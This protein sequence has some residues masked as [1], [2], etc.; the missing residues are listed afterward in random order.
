MELLS[1][2]LKEMAK[3]LLAFISC[4]VG[5]WGYYP[6]LPAYV[7]VCSMEGK[8][9][10]SVVIGA[11]AG[12]LAFMP[13]NSMIR[14]F[15]ILIVIGLAI[16]IFLWINRSCDS[17]STGIIAGIATV[18]MNFA[19]VGMWQENS[20]KLLMGICEGVMVLGLC[21]GIHA[22][23]GLPFRLDYMWQIW[24]KSDNP[25]KRETIR[26]ASTHRMESLAYAV[27]GLSDA[28]FAMSLP[29]KVLTPQRQYGEAEP[30]QVTEF[31]EEICE[32]CNS[33][34]VCW[35]E[36]H[37]QVLKMAWNN[38]L[39]ENRYVIARQLDAMADLMQ[40]WTKVRIS[41]D[42]K[43]GAALAAIIYGAKEKG[44]LVEDLHVYEEKGRLYT[45]G[46]VSAR[47][48]GGISMKHY[49]HVTEKA[50]GRDMRI[51]EEGK[52]ILT[53]DPVFVSLYEETDFYILQGA[54]TEKKSDS[55]E[56]GDYF[57]YFSMD[58]GNYHICLSDGMGSGSRAKEESEMVVELMQKFIEAGF[59]KETAVQLLNSTMV[60]QGEDNSFSTLD[61]AV[62]D[63]Y[64]GELELIKIGGAAT[65]IKHGD[66]VECID[67]G[68]LPAGAD[69]K[70]EVEIIKRKL[71]SGDFLVMV[72]DGM[73]EYLH[74][75]SPKDVMMDMISRAKTE[76]AQGLAEYIMTQVMI[77]TGGFPKDDMTI[78]V[79][80]I[81]EK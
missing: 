1:K 63:T 62:I 53:K 46:Y 27:S 10:I 25:V 7:A 16:R 75:R 77:L 81:W 47:L 48:N 13:F 4:L 34:E 20:A 71:M 39:M 56:N 38:R 65:F 32:H 6:L 74:V 14:Y 51:G 35:E 19:S 17:M 70:M 68:S 44:L 28:L 60:L 49:I 80:G 21:I 36:H 54:A 58:D 30:M 67:I 15:F 61:Y 52:N 26:G 31:Q 55:V 73:I 9:P 3:G 23:L 2:V 18:A 79:T 43:Y 57:S 64:T 50:L 41:A 40:E 11:V 33:R 78:L 5:F 69:A 45:E 42:H 29:K 76:N 8:A 72:T 37:G 66:E 24:D 59:K 22:V 12:I